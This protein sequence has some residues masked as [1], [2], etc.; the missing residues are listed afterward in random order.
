VLGL[1]FVLGA[2]AAL[3][4]LISGWLVRRHSLALMIL[5]WCAIAGLFG[6]WWPKP[7][8]EVSDALFLVFGACW[9]VAWGLGFALA[10]GLRVLIRKTKGAYGGNTG[11]SQ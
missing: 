11:F 9:L 1:L 4:G 6:Y 7:R 2:P 10:A 5:G 3:A 8:H